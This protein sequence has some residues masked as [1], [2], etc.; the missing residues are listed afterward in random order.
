VGILKDGNKEVS[1]PHYLL[2][3]PI[4]DM[5]EGMDVGLSDLIKTILT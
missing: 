2:D 5:R 3:C 1:V 4:I